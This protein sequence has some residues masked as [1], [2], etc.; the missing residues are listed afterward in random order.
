M[1]NE[2]LLNWKDHS[3]PN[4]GQSLSLSLLNIQQTYKGGSYT[5][6][7]NLK[8]LCALLWDVCLLMESHRHYRN[9]LNDGIFH[10]CHFHMLLQALQLS[11]W[12]SSLINEGIRTEY[13]HKLS[14]PK[15]CFQHH[16]IG[17]RLPH[18]GTG[19]D[20]SA[21]SEPFGPHI[22]GEA[23]QC[24]PRDLGV[25]KVGGYQKGARSRFWE[26]PPYLTCSHLKGKEIWRTGQNLA[27]ARYVW[28]L[29]EAFERAQH[30]VLVS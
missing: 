11:K 13:V 4:S 8:T 5:L 26:L 22:H 3:I 1:K 27:R 9:T 7:I 24:P 28:R 23:T 15:P 21:G 18:A 10:S 30:E 29:C 20:S 12:T 19:W 14:S 17:V 2:L 25:T 16:A 6:Y